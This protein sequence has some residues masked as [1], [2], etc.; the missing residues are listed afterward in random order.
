MTSRH[1]VRW[2]VLL[3]RAVCLPLLLAACEQDRAVLQPAEV[4]VDAT[5]LAMSRAA[6][7]LFVS[8]NAACWASGSARDPF[9]RLTDALHRARQLRDSGNLAV[10]T[11]H[12]MPGDY[13]VSHAPADCTV[14]PLPIRVD[15]SDVTI[16]GATQLAIDPET[17]TPLSVLPGASNFRALEALAVSEALLLITPDAHGVPPVRVRI[18]GLA[19]DGLASTGHGLFVDRAQDFELRGNSAR[20]FNNGI[21]T[22]GASGEMRG[23]VLTDNHD[24]GMVLTGGS[25]VSPA[26]MNV[27]GNR[28]CNGEIGFLLVGTGVFLL[29][30]PGA[31]PI[32]TS[33]DP[34]TDGTTIPNRLAVSLRDN[35]ACFNSLGGVR[36]FAV[37]QVAN[38]YA[39][40]NSHHYE[41]FATIDSRGNRFSENLYGVSLDAGFPSRIPDNSYATQ[42]HAEFTDDVFIGNTMG[43]GFLGFLRL[44]VALGRASAA[45]WLPLDR[46][47]ITIRANRGLSSLNF[48]HPATDTVT[49][50]PLSNTLVVNGAVLPNGSCIGACP[51]LTP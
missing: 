33:F 17:G 12:V 2:S 34:T 42:V 50:L 40:L 1:S 14:D 26:V 6:I 24:T 41:T 13:V 45:L 51:D 9:A 27:V 7:N 37:G 10:V 23:N 18:D 30:T 8:A 35:V 28:A 48:S 44:Q 47:T 4:T 22:R 20:R 39:L 25:T 31:A 29:S 16:H 19:L 21:R 15:L 32:D 3:Q 11:I 49:G 5:G 43:D 38:A 46:S 36:F